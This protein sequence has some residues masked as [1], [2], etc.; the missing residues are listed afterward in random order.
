[1]GSADRQNDNLCKYNIKFIAVSAAHYCLSDNEQIELTKWIF[2]QYEIVPSM[3][4]LYTHAHTQ[5]LSREPKW[6]RW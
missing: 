5:K 3:Q 2:V 1:M 4:L 6:K